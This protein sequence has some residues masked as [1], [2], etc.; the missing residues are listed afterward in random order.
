MELK[1]DKYHGAG[2][3]FIL[4]NCLKDSVFLSE[5]QIRFLCHRRLGIGADG[6]IM[7]LPEEDNDFRMKYF[8]ADGLEGSMCGNGGRTVAAYAFHNQ[9]SGSKIRFQAYDGRHEAEILSSERSDFQVFLTMKDVEAINFDEHYLIIDTGSPHYV[10]KVDNLSDFDVFNEGRKIRYDKNLSSKGL[11]VNFLERKDDGIFLRTYER[12]VE[13]ETLSCG[14]GVTAAA[15]ASSL[16]F[17]AN[18]YWIQTL[19]GLLFVRFSRN[20]NKFSKI[21][22]TGPVKYVFGGSIHL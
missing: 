22:L 1:F 20:G 17:G 9:I 13:D 12:G 21:E 5:E 10:T 11:N 7:L 19:G 2:N 3:D 6:L 8:N 16:W 15:I 18:E 14:T 4:I